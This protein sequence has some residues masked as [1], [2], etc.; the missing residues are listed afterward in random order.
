VKLKPTAVA[1]GIGEYGPPSAPPSQTW[2]KV[3]TGS[4]TT[5]WAKTQY[6]ESLT[7]TE[8]EEIALR[9]QEL[10]EEYARESVMD[11]VLEKIRELG[12]HGGAPPDD[13][14]IT[15]P[16]STTESSAL[17]IA[18]VSALMHGAVWSS[19]KYQADARVELFLQVDKDFLPASKFEVKAVKIISNTMTHG[20]TGM[21]A[22]R[23]SA[24]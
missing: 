5:G 18:P 6:G 1:Y 7:V 11:A 3:R 15:A 13:I 12:I 16:L 19:N 9:Q 23:I 20:L 8:A 21:Q 24:G 14:Q 4:N 10:L 2:T 17:F 22:V